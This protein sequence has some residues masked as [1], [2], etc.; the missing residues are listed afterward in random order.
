MYEQA[1]SVAGMAK[2]A[3][4]ATPL[5]AAQSRMAEALANIEGVTEKA[6]TRL[7]ERLITV[8][9]PAVPTPPPPPSMPGNLV[10][11]VARAGSEAVCRAQAHADE[12]T[13]ITDR[14][15]MRLS[16]LLERIEA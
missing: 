6:L 11:S 1:A 15:H 12:L 16:T 10:S 8:L 3:R 4:A 14:F 9:S 13:R 2:E 7:E 5:E